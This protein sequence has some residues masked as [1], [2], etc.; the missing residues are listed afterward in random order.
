MGVNGFAI[1]LASADAFSVTAET[2]IE[3]SCSC[4]PVWVAVPSLD[5]TTSCIG[6]E[7]W[8]LRV[9]DLA[10]ST[11][12][13]A[14][15]WPIPWRG[16]DSV[17][18]TREPD[19]S[20]RILVSGLDFR[21]LATRLSS[22]SRRRRSFSTLAFALKAFASSLAPSAAPSPGAFSLSPRCRSL[23]AFS[24]SCLIRASALRFACD[25]IAACL[26]A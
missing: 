4:G 18:S 7:I 10:E 23:A 6:F 17:C 12:S 2:S 26:A 22:F 8:E 19:I 16:P 14:V 13:E 9:V 5:F 21:A 20:A 1:L 24:S 15:L 11:T 25:S 3:A